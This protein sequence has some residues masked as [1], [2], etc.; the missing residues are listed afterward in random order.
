M[1]MRKQVESND[2]SDDTD[3][4]L[5]MEVV[6]STPCVAGDSDEEVRNTRA[7]RK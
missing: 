1:K 6:T 3:S 4:M 2:S 7:K 5:G